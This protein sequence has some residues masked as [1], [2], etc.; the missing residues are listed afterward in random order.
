MEIINNAEW[1]KKIQKENRYKTFLINKNDGFIREYEK[2]TTS[3]I[4]FNR[5]KKFTK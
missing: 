4:Q 2:N 5:Y 1:D 3:K